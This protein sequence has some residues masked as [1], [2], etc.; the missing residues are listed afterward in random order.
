VDVNATNNPRAMQY[1]VS[2]VLRRATEEWVYDTEVAGYVRFLGPV[3]TVSFPDVEGNE[4]TVV[5]EDRTTRLDTLAQKYY[6]DP[7]LWWVIAAR[8]ELDLPDQDLYPG[9]TLYVPTMDYVR[10]KILAGR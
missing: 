9:L 1:P 8:N 7:A 2:S 10:R 3:P 5:I 6:A 4:L